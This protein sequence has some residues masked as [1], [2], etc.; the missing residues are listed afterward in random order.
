MTDQMHPTDRT[1]APP[2][3]SGV[4]AI[5][6]SA[7]LAGFASGCVGIGVSELF[8]G[9][10]KGIPSLLVAVG[11]LIIRL[12]PPGA[13]DVVVSVLGVNDKLALNMLVVVVGLIAA[14]LAGLLASHRFELA[15]GVFAVFGFVAAA[16]GA[17]EPLGSPAAA[18]VNAVV[19][20]GTGLAT[21]W[22]LLHHIRVD[23]ALADSRVLDPALVKL[24]GRATE[25][26]VIET[27]DWSRRRFLIVSTGII[28]GAAVAGGFGRALIY[29]QHPAGIVTTSRLPTPR[30][31]VP[32]LTADQS[33]GVPGITQLVVPNSEFY[34]IDTALLV[35]RINVET[36]SLHVRGMV[37]RTLTITYDE[38]LAMPLFEQYVTL[39]CVSNEVGGH[40]VGNMLWT[41]VRL[42]HV[43]EMAGV[44]A[45]ATQIVGRSVD[46]FWAGFPTAW[47][48]APAREPMIAVG[49]NGKPLPAEHGF[50]ARLIV[51]GLFGYV[52]ATK[53]LSSIELTTR[54]AVDGYWIPLGYAKDGPILTESRIDVPKSNQVLIA[55]QVELA[56]VAWAPDRGI[57][58]VEARIDDGKWQEASIS[59]PI[60]PATWVQWALTW[61]ANAGRHAIEVRATDGNGDVQTD[62]RTNAGAP[63][64]ARGHHRISVLVG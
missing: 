53:W 33:L 37:D 31:R 23:R 22:V 7:A 27:R 4:R 1:A 13:K 35:P 5:S 17:R 61:Q 6:W 15:V 20:V 54:E 44:H 59:R 14:T 60:S 9:L 24:G 36:W 63:D 18:V 55:G 58:R 47:A 25:S 19:A 21:L 40:L 45:R 11:D 42:K 16:A 52:S 10:V 3:R 51:P 56:G 29:A 39:A 48:M 34:R 62:R 49:M 30:Q 26:S 2:S 64:G 50:P 28:G 46:E 41:G 38:L 32:V 43:L 8:A 12:Q 57:S